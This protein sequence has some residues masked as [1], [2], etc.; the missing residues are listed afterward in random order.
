MQVV[1]GHLGSCNVK[2]KCLCHTDDMAPSA[3]S[4]LTLSHLG[5]LIHSQPGGG[6]IHP[7]FRN[8]AFL[9]PN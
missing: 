2:E 4:S 5:D 9:D 8:F 3:T 6:R 7:L 1:A